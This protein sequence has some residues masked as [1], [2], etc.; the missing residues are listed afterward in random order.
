MLIWFLA[1][2]THLMIIYNVCWVGSKQKSLTHSN[3]YLQQLLKCRK[4]IITHSLQWL[5]TT[6]VELALSINHSLTL[7][8]FTTDVELALNNNHSLTPMIIDNICLFSTKQQSLTHSNNYL[9]RCWGGSKQ[10]SLT[11]SNDY[12]QQ[13]LR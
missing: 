6:E 5:F 1:T 4:A 2:I 13:L 8:I 12:L 9:Q 11:H 3:D 7:W 10:Q